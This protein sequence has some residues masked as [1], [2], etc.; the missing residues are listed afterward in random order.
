LLWCLFRGAEACS[1][2]SVRNLRQFLH[3]SMM[4]ASLYTSNGQ[5]MVDAL[6]AKINTV[7][8]V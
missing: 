5:A 4:E 8:K 2:P 1:L 6:V 7:L 3:S